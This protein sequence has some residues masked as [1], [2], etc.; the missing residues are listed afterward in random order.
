MAAAAIVRRCLEG[1]IPKPGA[2]PG[3]KDLEIDD[4]YPLFQSLGIRTGFRGNVLGSLYEQIMGEAFQRLARPLQRFHSTGKSFQMR[5][6]ATVVRGRSILSRVISAIIGFPASTEDTEVNIT[7]EPTVN[8]ELWTRKFGSH[9]F[10]SCQF[11]GKG[12]YEGLLVE[13]FGPFNFGLAVVEEHARLGLVVRGWD[14]LGL[15]LPRF[16]MPASS[17]IEHDADGRFNFDVKISLPV[18]GDVVH[19]RGWLEPV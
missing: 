4:Y 15:P 11:K 3:H 14:V 13:S 7:I 5:G 1:H 16:L 6:R 19:Y 9:M 2:R 18:G 12:R 17:A 10:R 8:R